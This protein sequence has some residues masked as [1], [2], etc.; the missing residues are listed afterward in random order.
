[1]LLKSALQ[2]FRTFLHQRI[3]K[4]GLLVVVFLLITKFSIGQCKIEFYVVKESVGRISDK[5]ANITTADLEDSAFITDEEIKM[6]SIEKS[7]MKLRGGKRAIHLNH[8]VKTT[9]DFTGKLDNLA[10]QRGGSKKFAL[11]VN[12][13]ILYW[14]Y[15]SSI[16]SSIVA[17]SKIEGKVSQSEMHLTYYTSK[18]KVNKDPR[19]NE[20]LFACL[21]ESNRYEFTNNR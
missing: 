18:P 17:D 19:K 7:K 10:L 4:N 5:K 1:M 16:L 13:E 11:V 20:R 14:G 21:K 6:Y 15:L 12:N 2:V 3:L 8:V 9:I